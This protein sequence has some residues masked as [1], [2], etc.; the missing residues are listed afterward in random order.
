MP[1]YI[2][3]D[4]FFKGP[5]L[6]DIFIDH[7]LSATI[8]ALSDLSSGSQLFK[9][10]PSKS[11]DM[12]ELEQLKIHFEIIITKK[13]FLEFQDEVVKLS[14]IQYGGISWKKFQNAIAHEGKKYQRLGFPDILR[15]S[16]DKN[17]S[18][19]L[20]YLTREKQDFM[21]NVVAL[22]L[23]IYKA[24]FSDGFGKIFR[25]LLD[26]KFENFAGYDPSNAIHGQINVS[27]IDG[28]GEVKI[29]DNLRGNLW[30]PDL[31]HGGRTSVEVDGRHPI[32]ELDSE[33][34]LNY[35]FLALAKEE[36][37]VFDENT[38]RDLEEFRFRVSKTLREMITEPISKG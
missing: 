38:K 28:I 32:Y 31:T 7:F 3:K 37:A 33:A 36:F 1:R 23:D 24:G 21:G 18:G 8:V 22:E 11:L 5:R 10:L 19:C 14:G 29:L 13:H 34:R 30:E 16:I 35:I 25:K 26:F 2:V 17:F 15:E 20:D 27:N 9:T 4:M 12:D 6:F